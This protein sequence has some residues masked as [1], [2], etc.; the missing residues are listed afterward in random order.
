MRSWLGLIIVAAVA[1]GGLVFEHREH[2]KAEFS[3]RVEI[4]ALK[5]TTDDDKAFEWL[6]EGVLKVGDQTISR[7]QLL[8][9]LLVKALEPKK[10]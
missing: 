3:L 10:K 1:L 7:A 2:E 6:Q 4:A 8:D 9:L 5:K